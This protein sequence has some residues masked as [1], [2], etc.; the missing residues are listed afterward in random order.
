MHD[1]RDSNLRELQRHLEQLGQ[2]LPAGQ[3]LAIEV[4]DVDLAGEVWP[5][6]GTEVRIVRGRL[7]WPQIELRYTLSEGGRT[8]ASGEERV[9][10]PSYL[11]GGRTVH[12]LG[13]LPYEKR[14][15]S[16]WFR[17]RFEAQD[18]AAAR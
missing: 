3:T 5:R 6:V 1:D 7:D 11:F 2:R 16:A 4:L 17:E 14:M 8:V 10:D 18:T 13:A 9:S 15:L 12:T